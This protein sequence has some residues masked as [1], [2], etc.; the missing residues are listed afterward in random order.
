M[1]HNDFLYGLNPEDLNKIVRVVYS[2]S[3]VVEIILFGSRAKG[4]Y[5]EGSDIDLA[6]ITRQPFTL[7]ELNTIKVELDELLL[8]Y[9]IDLIEFDKISNVDL[10]EHI[11]RVGKKLHRIP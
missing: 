6:L 11:K 9:K 5:K 4:T 7:F 10:V 1:S 3:K 2:H 8:P